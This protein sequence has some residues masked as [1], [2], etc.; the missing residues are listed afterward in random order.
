[1]AKDKVL[2]GIIA[3]GIIA[4]VALLTFYLAIVPNMPRQTIAG[5]GKPSGDGA[6]IIEVKETSGPASPRIRFLDYANGDKTTAVNG[7]QIYAKI[8][9]NLIEKGDTVSASDS[10]I[11]ATVGDS[12]CAWGFN[13]TYYSDEVCGVI[14][15]S[16]SDVITVPV[17]RIGDVKITIKGNTTNSAAE[18]TNQDVGAST[19]ETFNLVE[20][21]ENV[22]DRAFNFKGIYIDL[23]VNTNLTRGDQVSFLS[24]VTL[25]ADATNRELRG[26]S[27]SASGNL[28]RGSMPLQRITTDDITYSLATAILM[29]S[30]DRINIPGLTLD[31]GAN[32]CSGG[33]DVVNMYVVDEQRF[34][35]QDNTIKIGVETDA[36]SPADV[37]LGDKFFNATCS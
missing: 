6:A 37:G 1:M 36:S 13:A 31:A 11:S 10:T 35:G 24:P 8:N 7:L 29:I 28:V 4:M 34:L 12:Y 20:I 16:K 15:T 3:F 17:W 33:V 18:T 2:K 22:S 25:V 19:Q 30:G 23:A 9:G 26:L 5:D 21:R 27:L 32:G 14:K